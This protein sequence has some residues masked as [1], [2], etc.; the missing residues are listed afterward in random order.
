MVLVLGPWVCPTRQSCA[1]DWSYMGRESSDKEQRLEGHLVRNV[2][3]VRSKVECLSFCLRQG[4]S[5]KSFNFAEELG[6][7][8]VNAATRTTNPNDLVQDKDFDYY[9]PASGGHWQVSPLEAER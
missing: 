2:T 5:C 9:D 6:I 1:I 3:Q 7:C 4:D 8:Q